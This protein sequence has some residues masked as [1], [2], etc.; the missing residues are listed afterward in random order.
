M[1]LPLPTVS[2]HHRELY[3]IL[4]GK[5]SRIYNAAGLMLS[6]ES[7]LLRI[8]D[9]REFVFVISV[10]GELY[11]AGAIPTCHPF[12]AQLQ[13]KT[14]GDSPAI[15]EQKAALKKWKSMPP[16]KADEELRRQWGLAV[17]QPGSI[18]SEQKEPNA[19]EVP[20]V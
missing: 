9:E 5:Q 19:P 10:E 11:R 16:G 20:I 17:H 2:K 1:K 12:I 14:F 15:I 8:G 13:L 7:A 18:R 6:D 4:N 3:E